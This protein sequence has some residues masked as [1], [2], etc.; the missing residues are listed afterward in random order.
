MKDAETVLAE[1]REYLYNHEFN[2]DSLDD[3]QRIVGQSVEYE[4][5][6]TPEKR[7]T[8]ETEHG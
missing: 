5:E 3:L 6:V 4:S 7:F 1:V 8:G 2:A